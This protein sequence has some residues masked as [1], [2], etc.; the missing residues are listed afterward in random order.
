LKWEDLRG[1]HVRRNRR[2]ELIIRKFRAAN[3]AFVSFR[4]GGFR[5]CRSR[6]GLIYA[7]IAEVDLALLPEV[8]DRSTNNYERSSQQDTRRPHGLLA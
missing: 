2:D 6:K 3:I 4:Q 7:L 5:A 8:D 1:H